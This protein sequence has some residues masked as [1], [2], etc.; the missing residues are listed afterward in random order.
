MRNLWQKWGMLMGQRKKKW[1]FPGH[2]RK[3]RTI[4]RQIFHNCSDT[5]SLLKEKFQSVLKWNRNVSYFWLIN[6]G[7]RMQLKLYLI[8]HLTLNGFLLIDFPNSYIFHLSINW[9]HIYKY[10]SR[11]ILRYND[12][13]REHR[14]ALWKL[15]FFYNSR[16]VWLN[17]HRNL[18]L[19]TMKILFYP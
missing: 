7:E 2:E 6:T 16:A 3:L 18:F 19:T 13:H 17:L 15:W 11:C 1:M 12:H 10:P 8:I 4:F 9:S 5:L 14:S